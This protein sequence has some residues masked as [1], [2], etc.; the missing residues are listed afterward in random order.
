MGGFDIYKTKGQLNLWDSVENVEELNTNQDEM[1]LSFYNE[2]MG[3]LSSNRKG[4]KFDNSEYCCNDIFSFEY[5]NIEID[6]PSFLSI[7]NYLPLNLYFHNDEPDCCTMNKNTLKSYK[8]AYVSYYKLKKV[9]ENNNSSTSTFFSNILQSNFNKL[10]K[11]A[12]ALLSDLKKGRVLEITIKGF[13]SPLYFNDYNLNL[14]QRRISSFVNYLKEY[15]NGVFR[16]YIESRSLIITDLPL[17]ETNSSNSI[18]DNPKDKKNSIYSI[19]A[20]L[21]RK[22]EIVDIILKK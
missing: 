13:A 10:N 19:E 22:I 14:S 6:T 7:Y 4:A 1:Y 2:N 11:I 15:K 3:Y 16:S 5:T 18:S 20:M 9:Y 8:D 12:E 17:G 21:E